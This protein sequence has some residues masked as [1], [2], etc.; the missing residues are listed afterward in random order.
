[1]ITE[2][3]ILSIAYVIGIVAMHIITWKKTKITHN[4]FDKIKEIEDEEINDEIIN[5]VLQESFGRDNSWTK[6][7]TQSIISE[8]KKKYLL[9]V[10]IPYLIFLISSITLT[11]FNGIIGLF[12]FV[13]FIFILSYNYKIA[14][15][16]ITFKDC[17]IHSS[18]IALFAFMIYICIG[19]VCFMVYA[20]IFNLWTFPDYSMFINVEGFYLVLA[21]ISFSFAIGLLIVT[22]F[23]QFHEKERKFKK[24][25]REDIKNAIIDYKK[26][27]FKNI[28]DFL[29]NNKKLFKDIQDKSNI[30]TTPSGSIKSLTVLL[31]FFLIFGLVFVGMEIS[32]IITNITVAESMTNTTNYGGLSEIL[33]NPE[34]IDFRIIPAFFIL[35]IVTGLVFCDFIWKIILQS[36]KMYEE[37]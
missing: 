33:N 14:E 30:G 28:F 12:L 20:S 5:D 13:A 23:S 34:Y 35:V 21:G 36:S 26:K 18:T 37:E 15:D 29:D 17:I 10:I 22:S 8:D 2:I 1:M 3:L 16:K 32:I 25:L 7:I 9:Q 4:K 27:E 11:Y 24:G 31:F 6:I 19:L